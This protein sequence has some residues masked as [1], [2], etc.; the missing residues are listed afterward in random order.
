L[1]LYAACRRGEVVLAKWSHF[2]VD[3]DAPLWTVP[4]ELSKTGVKYLIPLVPAAAELRRLR[5]NTPESAFVFPAKWSDPERQADP[6]IL[7]RSLAPNLDRL[8]KHR[9]KPFILQ[10]LRRTVRTGLA[11]LKVK[12]H[13]VERVLNRA[14]RGVV[15]TY[16][17]HRYEGEKRTALKKWAAHLRGI[18]MQ[19]HK[20]TITKRKKWISLGETAEILSIES[21]ENV[22]EADVLQLALENTL[23][24][25]I[26]LSKPV[27]ASTG[28]PLVVGK[29][30]R[31]ADDAMPRIDESSPHPGSNPDTGLAAV[32]LPWNAA[33]RDDR[34]HGLGDNR[35]RP[36]NKHWKTVF[37]LWTLAMRGVAPNTIERKICALRGM[38]I[39]LR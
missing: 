5:I 4:E 18:P 13:I 34:G 37:G 12:P 32:E 2:R 25:A 9:I 20:A 30:P 3:G 19:T 10:D 39:P 35:H 31:Q 27:I 33:T 16:E 24:L 8:R 38:P 6:M 15:R 11:R 26:Y 21:G 22:S 1:I 17:L 14:Q 7:T 29:V 36:E 28:R 23:E